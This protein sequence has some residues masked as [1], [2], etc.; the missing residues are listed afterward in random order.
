[1][2][3]GNDRSASFGEL[4]AAAG[5][6]AVPR[7]VALKDPS[8]FTLIGKPIKRIEA[9]AKA[10]GSAVFGIDVLPPGLL[11]A[12]VVMCPTL[13]GTVASFDGAAAGALPGVKKVLPVPAT[14]AARPAWR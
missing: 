7:G 6:R 9:R 3:H 2:L 5:Q 13:G 14:T 10:N 8:A 12:S 1:M 11:Y 4:A